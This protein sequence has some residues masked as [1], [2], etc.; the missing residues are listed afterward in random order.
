MLEAGHKT[1]RKDLEK[2]EEEGIIESK[3]TANNKIRIIK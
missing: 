2:D 1:I 3:E